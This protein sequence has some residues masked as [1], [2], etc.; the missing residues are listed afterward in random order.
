MLNYVDD[1]IYYGLPS[2]ILT[3]YDFLLSLLQ[4]LGL[5]VSIK[6]LCPPSTNLKSDMLRHTFWQA[7]TLSTADKKMQ[8][9]NQ[10]CI[11]WSDKRVATKTDFQLGSLLYVTNCVRSSVS[12]QNV[13]VT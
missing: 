6:K 11:D 5:Q 2:V 8:E 1:L 3:T 7:R 13:A 10:M 12:Q 4:G 9:I